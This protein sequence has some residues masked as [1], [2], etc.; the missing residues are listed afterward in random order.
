MIF[1]PNPVRIDWTRCPIILDDPVDL[2]QRLGIGVSLFRAVE[3]VLETPKFRSAL[4]KLD[5]Q[6]QKLWSTRKADLAR[7]TA[8][9]SLD[10]KPW[11][12]AGPDIYSVRV[13]GNYRAHLRH[14]RDERV[15]F[16]EAI[17]DHKAMGHG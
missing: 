11:K 3:D 15:W 6:L 12:K 14:D 7:S 16:A 9:K 13:N 4:S 1:Y 5:S 17:G 8:L 2:L 10:F